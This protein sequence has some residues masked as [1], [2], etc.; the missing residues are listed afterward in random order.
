MLARSNVPQSEALP[1]CLCHVQGHGCLL[2]RSAPCPPPVATTLDLA[3][4]LLPPSHDHNA[5][6]FTCRWKGL[7]DK[8]D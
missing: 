5:I 8:L 1:C 7:E 3:G 6:A 4:P 2:C